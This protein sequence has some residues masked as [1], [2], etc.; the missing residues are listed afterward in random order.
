MNL[1]FLMQVRFGCLL[2]VLLLWYSIFSWFFSNA[3][4]RALFCWVNI[5]CM[6]YIMFSFLNVTYLFFV[7]S[8]CW[9]CFVLFS[10]ICS[11]WFKKCCNK[12]LFY[13]GM[14]KES[15]IICRIPWGERKKNPECIFSLLL[16]VFCWKIFFFFIP[17]IMYT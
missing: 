2:I 5:S 3:C 9:L 17:S 6:W 13:S 15:Y 10:W 1:L 16:L 4:S 14:K 7:K 12:E 11:L 8:E